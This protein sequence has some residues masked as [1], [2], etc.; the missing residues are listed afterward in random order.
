[1]ATYWFI[2]GLFDNQSAQKSEVRQ[3]VK[4]IVK[5]EIYSQIYSS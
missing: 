4:D 3:V 1:M 2:I 5:L